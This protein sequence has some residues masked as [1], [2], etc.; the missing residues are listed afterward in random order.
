MWVKPHFWQRPTVQADAISS[1]RI[2][3]SCTG[4]SSGLK[5]VSILCLKLI[6]LSFKPI[7]PTGEGVRVKVEQSP[8]KGMC[9]VQPERKLQCELK[10]KMSIWGYTYILAGTMSSRGW[11]PC[12]SPSELPSAVKVLTLQFAGAL[13]V[14]ICL[15]W[16]CG[17][18]GSQRDAQ[19]SPCED[20]SSQPPCRALGVIR[21]VF[22]I[23][24][25]CPHTRTAPW[26]PASSC[27]SAA[28]LPGVLPPRWLLHSAE[29]QRSRGMNILERNPTSVSQT[30]RGCVLCRVL[31]DRHWD[32]W[33]WWM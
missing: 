14:A 20:R 5:N 3:E 12:G 13:W 30:K 10:G 17:R 16:G 9:D 11:E 18:A 23:Q 26:C 21:G 24:H 28:S 31:F 1:A 25:L 33:W 7:Q 4:N 8:V 19:L 32:E 6:V 22:S 2:L 29:V 15:T 27:C